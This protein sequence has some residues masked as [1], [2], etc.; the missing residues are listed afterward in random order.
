MTAFHSTPDILPPPFPLWRRVV[1]AL[2]LI[3]SVVCGFR[4]ATSNANA[5]AKPETLAVIQAIETIRLGQRVVGH[6]PLREQTQAAAAIEPATWRAVELHS[7]QYGVDY[8]LAFLRPLSWIEETGAKVGGSIDLVMPEIGLDGLAEVVAIKP[9][10]VIDPDD[11][12]GRMVVTGWMSH[13]A[14]NVLDMSIEGEAQPLGVTD[15]H[16]MWSEDRHEFVHAGELRVG[17]RLQRADGTITQI[18]RITPHTGPPVLTYNLEVD[19]E[20][21]Y[22]VGDGSLL[23]HNEGCGGRGS[24]NPTIKSGSSDYLVG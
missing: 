12:T 14:T 2:C 15:T 20:H 6:N 11:G 1:I 19:G 18:T 7:F 5:S 4:L 22:R 3:V 16:P 24:N 10:P 21:V 13:P 23:V 8:E 9:C 17:E